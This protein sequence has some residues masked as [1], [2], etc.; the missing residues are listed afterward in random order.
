M[1]GLEEVGA[2]RIS[3]GLDTIDFSKGMQNVNARMNALNSEFK[4][5]TAGSAKFDNSLEALGKRSDVLTR[6]FQT[7]QAKVEE[8]KRRYEES[9]AAKGEDATETLKAASAYNRAVASLQNLQSQLNRVNSQIE[10]QSNAWKNLSK[11]TSEI[12]T[13]MQESGQKVTDVGQKLSGLSLPIVSFGAAAVNT[14]I[15][16]DQAA[17][18]IQASLGVTKDEADNLAKVAQ[19]LWKQ[20]FGDDLNAATEAVTLIKQ[21]LKGIPTESID[22]IAKSALTLQKTFS[23]D[24]TDSVRASKALIDN[25]GV[26]ASKAFD[27]IT[28]GAQKG[29]DFSKELLDTIS[30]YSTQFSSA[31]ISV[32]G[33]FNILIQG[34][35]SGAWN[36]DKVG[37]AVKEFNIRAKDGSKTTSDGF[38][39]IGLDVDDMSQKIAKGG[40]EGEKA[41]MATVSAL[42]AMK[43]PVQKNIA[44]VALFG[45]QWEDLSQKVVT[46]LNPAINVMDDVTGA[47]QRAGEALGYNFGAEAQQI[48]RNF[49]ADMEPVG[50]DLLKIAD[51]ILPQAAASIKSVT[52]AFANMSPETQKIV[53]TLGA[54][55]VA[56]GPVLMGIGSITSGAGMLMTK[57]APLLGFLGGSAGLSGVLTALTGPI[58]LTVGGLALATTAGFA[59]AGAMEKAKEVNLDHAKSLLDQ[60]QQLDGLLTKYDGLKEKNKLSNDELLRF[61]DIQSE[62]KTAKSADEVGKLKDEA[63]KLREKSGLSNDQ[64][65]NMLSLNDQLIQK[66]PVAGQS[67]SDQGN[68][69]L[70]N[71]DDIRAANDALREN[72]KL[73]LDAQ[74]TKAEAKLDENIRNQ[75]KAAEELKAKVNELNQAKIE[76]LGKE[77]QLEAM[78]K[79]QQ[80]AYAAG[81]GR[82]AQGMND[83]IQRLQFQVDRQNTKVGSIANE[84]QKKQESVNKSNEEI[85]KVQQLF[86]DMINL[87]LAQA[88]IN[89]KGQEGIAQLDQTI[90]KTQ[91]RITELNAVGESQTGLNAEQQKEL[92]NLQNALGKYQNT[93]SEI[94]GIQSEQESVNGKIREGTSH[95]GEMSSILSQTERKKIEFVGNGYEDAKQISDEAGRPATKTVTISAVL[96]QAFSAAVRA[97]ELINHIDIPGFAEGTGNAPGGLALVGENGPELMYVPKGASVIPNQDTN[98]ILNKWGVPTT[99]NS[100]GQSAMIPPKVELHI[101]NP[102]EADISTITRQQERA[103]T[104]LA[105]QFRAVPG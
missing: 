84:V 29:G 3:L 72:L 78:K 104:N 90:S 91:A 12:G 81:Q 57:V 60:R 5:V 99:S 93:R 58:G 9:A 87:Q 41:F 30:E 13:N 50:K 67:F 73:E 95:A 7:Q 42:A 27:Y 51:D 69:I 55:A 14:A 79:Q 17:G 34:A 83:E 105:F 76:G 75:V 65:S 47:T 32:D 98:S 39:A 28:V 38:K 74:R 37:D 68:K 52:G 64:L 10:E 19:T 21:Q 35:Q 26:D 18:R 43:D 15:T 94:T 62:L 53:I 54:V 2:L 56:A 20:G 46:G 71:T 8:L 86:G 23:Y 102:K 82:I 6:M 4:A 11:R 1:K 45:T 100:P 48:W 25:F 63:E 59:M 22:P 96:S 80:D 66:V 16:F 85:Q 49:Q 44:G 77:H 89:T 36:L 33:M 101:H 97:F 61:R 31:G 88:G 40:Q 92:E 70:K 103:W 24:L